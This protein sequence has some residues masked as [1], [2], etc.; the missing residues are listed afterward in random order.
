MATSGRVF[1][2]NALI[3]PDNFISLLFYFG[4]LTIDRVERGK[5]VLKVPNLTIRQVLFSYIE[6]G[7]WEADVFNM[8]GLSI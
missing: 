1:R 4:I 5:T 7:Y 2:Q 3:D 8:K 6:Q